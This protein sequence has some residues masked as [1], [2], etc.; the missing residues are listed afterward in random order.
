M[1]GLREVEFDDLR[2]QECRARD[3]VGPC[4]ACEGMICGDCGVLSE[5]PVGT[6]CICLSCARLIADVRARPP[7]RSR[8][9]TQWVA[10]AVIAAFAAAALSLL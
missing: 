4:A 1:P 9:A 6:R 5:D 3:P 8:P 7:R 10:I 2:C